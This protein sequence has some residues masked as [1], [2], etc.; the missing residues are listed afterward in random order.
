MPDVLIFADS[1]RSAELRHE[2]PLAIPERFLYVER[3]GERHV[4]L[5]SY[6][7]DRLQ[8][9]GT[10]LRA[11][12]LEE[13]GIDELYNRG[14]S[15][16]EVNLELKL[17]AVRRFGLETAVVPPDFPL[18]VAD[19]LRAHGIELTPDRDFF[20]A[21]RRVKSPLELA[22]I[23]RAQR[24]AEAG[25]AVVRELLGRAEAA[26]GKLL[27]EGEPLTCE[28]IRQRVER[29]FS[30]RGLTAE[31]FIVSHG[32]QTALGH[33]RGSGP[34]APGEPVVADL[35]PRDP[36]SGCYAD[37][38]RTFVAPGGNGDGQE[39]REYHRLCREAL[40]RVLA[41]IRPGAAGRDLHRIACDVFQGHGYKTQ[42]SKAP[43][44]VLL[45]G[46]L[47]ALGHGV[48]LELHEEPWLGRP[49]SELVAGDV[50][51]VEPGL[52]R[53]GYGG[54]RLEDLVLVTEDGA[55][56]LTEFP[57]DLEP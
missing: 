12:P 5:N 29:A 36:D 47:H 25:M 7:I 27:L 35:Y 3:D 57:Y 19:H 4:V 48:G 14:L 34:I 11:H 37:M 28:L 44:E 10:D 43:D 49:P 54:C 56:I 6:E 18:E 30:E 1:I 52:Y 20:V 24:G 31:E 41:A 46:F 42:L 22:G 13:F 45:D 32:P 40:E 39:L 38:T 2:V 50:I 8:A 16:K 17:A 15:R 23:R 51:A 33:E 53:S 21:R 9:L 26:N 55:D